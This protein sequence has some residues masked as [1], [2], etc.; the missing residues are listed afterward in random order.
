[1]MY[2]VLY[3]GAKK[4]GGAEL[5]KIDSKTSQKSTWGVLSESLSSVFNGLQKLGISMKP[6]IRALFHIKESELELDI[7]PTKFENQ[8]LYHLISCVQRNPVD[9]SKD[10][11]CK[12]IVLLVPV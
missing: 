1:M 3:H 6:I 9:D 10:D 12:Y 7:E 5:P 8:L 4:A 2:K 11:N